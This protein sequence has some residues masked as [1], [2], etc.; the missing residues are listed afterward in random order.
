MA[1]GFYVLE[2]AEKIQEG[3][4]L[5]EV[6]A[7]LNYLKESQRAYFMVDDLTHLQRGGRL[8]GAQAFIGSLLKV[9]PIL[10]FDNKLI[11]PFEKIRTRKKPF[12]VFLN[13][14]MK[15]HHVVFR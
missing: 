3:A 2:A 14:L 11:V 12:H 4:S 6:L 8:N 7:H 5:E 9:K 15:M 1:Q 10:H 13:Y